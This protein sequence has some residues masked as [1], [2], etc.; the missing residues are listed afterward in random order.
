MNITSGQ[1]ATALQNIQSR[2]IKIEL[3]NYQFQTVDSLEGICT[4]GSISIDANADI[5]RTGSITLVIKD[6]TF[7]VESKSQIWLDKYVRVWVGIASLRTGEI[8]YVNCGLFIIDAPTYKYDAST[9]TLTLSLLDLMAKLTGMRNGYLPGV[10]VVLSAGENIR[11]AIIDTLA[12]GGFTK[13]VVEEAP[14]PGT[15]PN[16]LEF[17]QGATVYDLLAGLR[18]IYPGYE[19]FFDVNGVFYYKPIPT[20]D[21]EPILVDDTTWQNVVVSEQ[22]VVDFQNVKNV[23]E[24]YGRTHDPAHFSTKTTVS[25]TGAINLTIA[26]VSAY[27]EGMIYGFTLTDNPGYTSP[28]L[29][30]NSLTTY[31]ILM[32]DGKTPAKIV[33]ESGEIYFCVEF[34]G[35][36][37]N[38]LGHLQAYGYAEDD[39]PQSP[40]YINSTVGKI[41]LPLFDGEYANCLSDDLAQQRA[42]RELFLHTN[43]NNS[44]TLSCVP[45]YWMDVNILCTH[46]LATQDTIYPYIIKS[47][48]LG[49]ASNDNMT[50]NMIRYYPN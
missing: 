45:V 29:Q 17:S 9:N 24:V 20:G 2:Y 16:D 36:Y 28:T 4:S 48:N 33:A 42:K 40:F 32:S 46:K 10:P 8:E 41:R 38:W 13:Y 1:F 6:G 22:V 3:L 44:V 27:K 7:Q 23:I 43:M 47:I 30:I 50:V 34:K 37:W 35:T 21:N 25:S 14:S 26:D 39:N 12:L 15:I 49:L 19:I 18:D 31:P 5:R 11:Q